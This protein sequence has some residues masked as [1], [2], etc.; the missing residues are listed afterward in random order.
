M[1][2]ATTSRTENALRERALRSQADRHAVT[3]ESLLAALRSPRLGDRAARDAA[4][5]IA[6]RSLVALRTDSD[7]RTTDALEPVMGAFARLKSDLGPLVRFGELDVQFVEPPAN[8]RALPGDVAHA[9][10]A[11]VRNAVLAFVDAAEAKRVRIHWDCDGLNLLIGLRDDGT[12]E[13]TAHDDVLRPIAEHVTHL[14]GTLAVDST[15]GWGS[16]I[17]IAIPLD[18]PQHAPAID[19]DLTDREREILGH[20]VTGSRNSEIAGQLNISPHTV[21]FHVSKLLR[22][23]GTRNRA[24][25]AALFS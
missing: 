8:G 17:D 25:L 22:R 16:E 7:E 9:A 11:I 6:S 18:P 13:L 14:D 19:A 2:D 24:E 1:P 23:T 10:R 20:L 4:I 12:G 15:P 5:D 3:L 21:K